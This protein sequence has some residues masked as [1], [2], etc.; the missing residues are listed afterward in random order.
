VTPK[1]ADAD[2]ADADPADPDPAHADQSVDERAAQ[3]AEELSR[4]QELEISGHLA[5]ARRVGEAVRTVIDLLTATSAPP[6]VLDRAADQLASVVS[7]LSGYG[8]DRNYEG[9]AEASGLGRELAFFDWSPLLGRANPLAP[10]IQVEITAGMVVGQVRFGSA[11][12]G[13]P[14]CVHGGL[15][16]A[17][18]DEVLGL[19]QSLSGQVGMT[20]RLTVHYRHP[21]PLHTDLRF[22]GRLDAV[23]GRKV[24]TSARLYAGGEVTAE[25]TGL[26]VTISAE[27][28][29]AMAAHRDRRGLTS[30][31]DRR[32]P[33]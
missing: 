14:G 16:A 17:G 4:I 9:L 30:S 20:G 23:S 32:G 28:F 7:L 22:E 21:T 27:R 8:G 31:A 18:F 6:E 33:R 11:Y 1:G 3:L 12:E 10:P 29:Q 2:Q 26:F 24:L 5:S 25:A 19:A 13:P 15:I